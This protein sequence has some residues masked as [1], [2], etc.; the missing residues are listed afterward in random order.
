[1]IPFSHYNKKDE[2]RIGLLVSQHK[3]L[4]RDLREFP[5]IHLN[6]CGQAARL[7]LGGKICSHLYGQVTLGSVGLDPP[8]KVGST[9][10]LSTIWLVSPVGRTANCKFFIWVSLL[11]VLPI[12]FNYNRINQRSV[13]L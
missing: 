1:M 12:I 11:N 9:P 6:S 13:L 7:L 8:R 4:S 5:S 2:Y 10:T 3:N